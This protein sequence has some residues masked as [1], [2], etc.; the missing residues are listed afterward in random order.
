MCCTDIDECSEGFN[1]CENNSYCVN[2]IGSYHC[3][4]NHGYEGDGNNCSKSMLIMQNG[5]E[6]HNMV[7]EIISNNIICII[8]H[9]FSCV[10]TYT[11]MFHFMYIDNMQHVKMETFI[12]WMVIL[13]GKVEWRY[14]MTMCMGQ[15]VMTSGDHSMLL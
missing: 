7:H 5:R 9:V 11:C 1:L 6:W 4:C 13:P 14:V 8:I 12:C 10:T 2:T 15:C 3:Q